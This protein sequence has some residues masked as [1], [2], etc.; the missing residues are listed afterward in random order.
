IYSPK[1]YTLSEKE[2]RIIRPISSISIPINEI[3]KV[4][5]KE[6]NVFKTI[7][8]W[9]NGGVFSLSGVFYN[10]QDGK[11]WMYAKNS[12]YIMIHARK[13]YVLSPD[14]KEQFIIKVKNYLG[15]QKKNKH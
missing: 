11:F 7:R 5:D 9:A 10:K 1:K 2:I 8:L 14:E 4:E 12:R 3:N 15:K 13:K 6:I